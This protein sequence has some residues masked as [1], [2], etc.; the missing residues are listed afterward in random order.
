MTKEKILAD[1]YDKIKEEFKYAGTV[2]TSN[3][4]ETLE[5]FCEVW[6]NAPIVDSPL[7]NIFDDTFIKLL[8]TVEYYRGI[9]KM[10]NTREKEGV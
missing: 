2:E 3:Y 8:N 7:E 9:E 1:R 6:R 10:E 4:V 5:M